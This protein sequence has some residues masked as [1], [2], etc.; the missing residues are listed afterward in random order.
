[1]EGYIILLILLS[2]LLSI[3]T[4]IISVLNYNKAIVC[5]NQ[6]EKSSQ[7]PLSGFSKKGNIVKLEI[8]TGSDFFSG[9]DDSVAIS[10][11]NTDKSSKSMD[12]LERLNPLWVNLKSTNSKHDDFER[13]N[14]DTFTISDDYT[15]QYGNISKY[16]LTKDTIKNF[17]I[18]K[19]PYSWSIP[20][21]GTFYK[22]SDDW[23][24]SRIRLYLNGVL[25]YDV[26]P[27]KWFTKDNISW[28]SPN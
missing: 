11:P 23:L 8:T 12:P 10:F 13:K 9:T 21:L 5:P 6:L 17:M 2:I 7:I 18:H 24:L 3:V 20:G 27:N 16:E 28:Q 4:L 19:T 14:V 1:M 22:R 25:M 26:K 15:D